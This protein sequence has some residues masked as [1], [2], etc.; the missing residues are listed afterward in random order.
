MPW[1][2]QVPSVQG[3]GPPRVSRIRP[4]GYVSHTLPCVPEV[5]RLPGLP[6]HRAAVKV[7]QPASAILCTNIGVLPS[8]D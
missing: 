1:D 3:N 7:T 4:G 6:W 8:S 2:R 5:G